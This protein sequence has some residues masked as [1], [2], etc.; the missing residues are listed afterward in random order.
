MCILINLNPPLFEDVSLLVD[1]GS[2][3]LEKDPDIKRKS[4]RQIDDGSHALK[5]A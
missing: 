1:F 5:K 2:M 4:L 3:V